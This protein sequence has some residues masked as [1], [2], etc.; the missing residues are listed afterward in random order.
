MTNEEPETTYNAD[1]SGN[2]MQTTILYGPPGNRE[3][4][5]YCLLF[6]CNL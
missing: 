3:N 6:S 2:D 1:Q 5:Q 4:V